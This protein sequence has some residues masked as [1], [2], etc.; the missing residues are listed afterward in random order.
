AVVGV[1]VEA[2]AGRAVRYYL[3]VPVAFLGLGGAFGW[4]IALA[5]RGTPHHVAAE[6]ALGVDGPTLFLQGSILVL[7]L[8]SLLLIAERGGD[9]A[10]GGHFAAQASALPGTEAEQR[11]SQ[12]GI[13]Q[14]EVFPL[15]MFTVGG[16]IM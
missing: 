4:T 1:L 2:F 13:R 9:R 7:A 16:M 8:V 15:M 14:T 6:G 3:Q 5:W 12:A 10:A 11:T